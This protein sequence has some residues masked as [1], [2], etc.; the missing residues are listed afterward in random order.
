MRRRARRIGWWSARQPGGGAAGPVREPSELEA[1]AG[2]DVE[3]GFDTEALGREAQFLTHALGLA[4]GTRLQF[5][6]EG[7]RLVARGIA[8]PLMDKVRLDAAPL[9]DDLLKL[10]PAETPVLLALQLKLPESLDA[11]KTLKRVLEGRGPGPVRT[12]QMALVWTP[13]GDAGLGHEFALLW[14]RAEDAAALQSMFP[15]AATGW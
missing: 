10:V 6:V 14:G 3:L 8:G 11:A 4:N 15:A 5:A 9:S 13:R 1:P 7:N 12:R 2:V